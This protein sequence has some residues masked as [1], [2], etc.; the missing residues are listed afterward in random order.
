[1]KKLPFKEFE[2]R[3]QHFVGKRNQPNESIHQNQIKV[4]P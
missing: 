1:M 2:Q 4:K 3:E